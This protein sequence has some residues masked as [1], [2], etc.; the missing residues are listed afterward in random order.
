MKRLIYIIVF[1][2]LGIGIWASD[3]EHAK[4]GKVFAYYVAAQEALAAD[5][6]A[7]AKRSLEH[8][9]KHSKGEL[10]SLLES[11]LKAGDLNALR[12]A[13][14]PLSEHIAKAELP[15]GLAV[16]YCPMAK[17]HWVQKN[18][19]VANPYYGSEMLRCGAIK[20]VAEAKGQ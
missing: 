7:E 5:N 2:S 16:A 18:G 4:E 10:K 9:A 12:H 13:F 14:K 19:K 6:Y 3:S 8:L 17:A 1:I 11:V 15:A 20:K